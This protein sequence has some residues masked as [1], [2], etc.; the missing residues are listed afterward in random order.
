MGKCANKQRR[1]PQMR[2]TPCEVSFPPGSS[3]L[4]TEKKSTFRHP[5]FNGSFN[6][7]HFS[8][9][10]FFKRLDPPPRAGEVGWV[11]P[12]DPTPWGRSWAEDTPCHPWL[13]VTKCRK[14]LTLKLP[15]SKVG[16]PNPPPRR[17][18]PGLKKKINYTHGAEILLFLG[19]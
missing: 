10:W 8:H 13:F 14:L 5:K 2:V 17:G 12:L 7:C 4:A 3:V 18:T 19:L 15:L 6:L 1:N 9:Q 11:D 16:P